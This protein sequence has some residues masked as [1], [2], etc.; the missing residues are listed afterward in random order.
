[1]SPDDKEALHQ[2]KRGTKA[3]LT[4]LESMKEAGAEPFSIEYAIMLVR[5]SR[6]YALASIEFKGD[7]RCTAMKA[8]KTLK[9]VGA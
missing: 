5:E 2:L 7:P 3:L 1:M 4:T 8:A 6:N 9:P